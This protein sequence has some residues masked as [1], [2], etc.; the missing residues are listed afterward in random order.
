[1]LH[2]FR[3][4]ILQ[5][6]LFSFSL[7]LHG[8][9]TKD[10]KTIYDSISVNLSRLENSMPGLN[11]KINIS[12][13]DATLNEF[14]RAIAKG[15]GV[16][17]N[18][19][20]ELTQKIVNN[21]NN[22]SISDVLLFI[23]NQY[24]LEL[25]S[26]GNIISIKPFS[27][28]TVPPVC[29]IE[30][31]DSTGTLT[32]ESGGEDLEILSK[33]LTIA[34]GYNI[35]P[36]PGLGSQKINAFIL[37]LPLKEALD[38]I[39]YSNNLTLKV[40]DSNVFLLEKTVVEKAEATQK[41]DRNNSST[42]T[43]NEDI[44]LIIRLL[45]EDSL[46]IYAVNAPVL[47][48]IKE[49]SNKTDNNYVITTLPK[50][51]VNT[52]MSGVTYY[53]TL[54]TILNG[55]GLVC[56]KNGSIY[57]IGNKDTPE[58]MTQSMIQLQYRSVDSVLS[59]IPKDIR[60]DV[61]IIEYR[62]QNSLL[63]S[64]PGNEVLQTE[65]YIRSIDKRVPVISI[66]II[67]ID[68]SST[69]T[70]STGIEAGI[71]KTPVEKTTGA[72]FPAT[73]IVLSSESINSL[74]SRF[75][76]FGWA[77]L[78]NVTPNFYASLKALETQGIVKIRSTP[79]LSTVNGHQA[80]LSIGEMEYYLEEQSNIYSTTNTQTLTTKSYKSVNADLSVIITPQVSGDDQITLEI[81]VEQSDFTERITATAPPGE[82]TRKFKS[83]IR[84]KNGEMILLGGL[85]ENRQDKTSS[86][87]PFLSRIPIIK[88]I[89]SS[90]TEASARTKLNIF[91]KPSIIN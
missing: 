56:K 79:I 87:T 18:I 15:S 82:V 50:G 20:P 70:E 11:E 7:L 75:N 37:S 52:Q 55:S 35:I 3:K 74:I 25:T 66:E 6:L 44:E 54:H 47:D 91:I 62:E 26:I 42:K 88:W 24:R 22:V 71:G 64:G 85:E 29:I 89:F 78:G 32:I 43:G 27:E 33:K 81:E 23:C 31:N 17:M 13:T 73:E 16:N 10:W 53:E 9:V 19:S 69:Y 61:Q 8:Q 90:R 34:S 60:A 40:T 76:G 45:G 51:E 48:V 41:K 49:L 1:M 86:G 12:I 84:V 58:L 83:Q 28:P 36:A 14:L 2:F 68:Y 67:I 63:L 57:I 5:G 46:S 21:F 65:K 59:V 30:Y 72:V 39:A 80:E 4:I 77:K 38:K